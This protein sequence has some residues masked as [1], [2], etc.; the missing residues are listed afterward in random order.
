[1][2]RYSVAFV[3]GSGGNEKLLVPFD[4]RK[5]VRKFRA[6]IGRRLARVGLAIDDTHLQLRLD[7]TTGP[8]LDGEDALSTVVF[9]PA[10]ETI[11]ALDTNTNSAYPVAESAPPAATP[12]PDNDFSNGGSVPIKVRVLT[13]LLAKKHKDPNSAPLIPTTFSQKTTLRQ[14]RQRIAQCLN[15][16][17]NTTPDEKSHQECNCSLA[18]AIRDGNQFKA[19]S[20]FDASGVMRAVETKYS[21]RPIVDLGVKCLNFYGLDEAQCDDAGSDY[22]MEIDE[23]KE[24]KGSY[25]P[26]I[27]VSICS[28]RRHQQG[29]SAAADLGSSGSSAILDLHTS[30]S[31]ITTPHIDLTLEDLGL[32][33]LVVNGALTLFAVSRHLARSV[34]SDRGQDRIYLNAEH[35]E[36][37]IQQT[38][39]G[40]AMFLSSLRVAAYFAASRKSRITHDSFLHVLHAITRFPPPPFEQCISFS[41][42]IPHLLQSVQLSSKPVTAKEQALRNSEEIMFPYINS[43]KFVHLTNSETME[44]ITFPVDTVLGLMEKGCFESLKSG[45]LQFSKPEL[46]EALQKTELDGRT[47]WAA[48]LSAGRHVSEVVMS[49][50]EILYSN[51]KDGILAVYLGRQGCGAEPGRDFLIYRP[52]KGGECAVDVSIITQLLEPIIAARVADGTAI[53]DGDFQTLTKRTDKPDEILMI[54]VDCSASMGNDANFEDADSDSEDSETETEKEKEK[55]IRDLRSN[56][57]YV[58]TLD[59]M[60]ETVQAYES[61]DDMIMTVK[62][63][64]KRPGSPLAIAKQLIQRDVDIK[65][66]E[67]M[68][69]MELLKIIQRRFHR[70]SSATTTAAKAKVEALRSSIAGFLHHH[71]ALAE[72]LIYRACCIVDADGSAPW[73][74][75]AGNAVPNFVADGPQEPAAASVSLELSVPPEVRCPMT[76]DLFQSPVMTVDGHTYGEA[77]IRNWFR[78]SGSQKSPLTNLPLTSKKLSQ[79]RPMLLEVKKWFDASDLLSRQYSS[80]AKRS[81]RNLRT[82]IKYPP[83]KLT[84]KYAFSTFSRQVP[85]AMPISA[86]YEVAFR[87]M[88]GQTPIFSL[89]LQ[90][91]QVIEPSDLPV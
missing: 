24:T 50:T 38:E 43:M 19:A 72:F 47:R 2:D 48:L 68:S 67:L 57:I 87:G 37:P 44:S 82:A 28:I 20:K 7:S 65:V 33:E 22:E 12:A 31:P 45:I 11:V 54:C 39:R 52:T 13:P 56:D 59:D 46:N 84:F 32:A 42:A 91:N 49:D 15:L 70:G 21:R 36:L 60:K 14:L 25:V 86:L 78:T 61:F 18:R 27:I 30:E 17:D 23:K 83:I 74:W 73:S 4:G 63:C 81:G 16:Q 10:K 71:T 58:G 89:C 1:M 6:E 69:K 8:L 26:P 77:A 55:L 53:F 85:L 80:P 62:A 51:Y 35:W 41:T 66:D 29:T 34:R 76:Q 3:P 75:S 88:R 64:H 79:N 40:T 5:T 9:L 90:D